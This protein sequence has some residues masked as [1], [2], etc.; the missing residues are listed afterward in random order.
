MRN[1]QGPVDGPAG[2]QC[3]LRREVH[4]ALGLGARARTAARGKRAS[5]AGMV[6]AGLGDI[7]RKGSDS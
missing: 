3:R 5:G 4:C 7:R 1:N 6:L 2:S